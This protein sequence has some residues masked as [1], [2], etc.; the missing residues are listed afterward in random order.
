MKAKRY[1]WS[2][3]LLTV[4]AI[5]VVAF[6]AVR[7]RHADGELTVQFR[8]TQFAINLD[9]R[10]NADTE[11]R[12]IGTLLHLGLVR[13]DRDGTVLPAIASQWSQD[14]R[15]TRFAISKGLTFN[16]GSPLDLADIAASLCRSMQP[17]AIF[18][19]M[20][21]SIEHVTSA[22][23]KSVDCTGIRIDAQTREIV[24]REALSR[25]KDWLLEALASPAGWVT[26]GD[27]TSAPYR[28]VAGLGPYRLGAVVADR[29]VELVGRSGG[30][31]RPGIGR[32]VFNLITD[33]AQAVASLRRGDL[34]LLEVLNP[35]IQALLKARASDDIAIVK[36]LLSRTRILIV[37]QKALQQL[38]LQAEAAVALQAS[39]SQQ[40]DREALANTTD[41]LAEAAVSPFPFSGIHQ[42]PVNSDSGAGLSRSL[43][44]VSMNDP[45]SDR[46]AAFVA[47]SVKNPKLEYVALEK[48]VFFSRLAKG[49]FDI[50]SIA[51]ESVIEA[52]EFW[53]A[54]FTPGSPLVAFGQPIPALLKS[55]LSTK[56]ERLRALSIAQAESNWIGLLR[57]KGAFAVNKRLTGIRFTPAGQLSLEA[58]SIQ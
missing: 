23:Q 25:H 50:A 26:K 3:L 40:L 33:D 32:I 5:A 1:L 11:S 17:D 10:T 27:P 54:F 22:D 14:G 7:T 47:R 18:S 48:S 53:L 8:L 43:Q 16:D 30:P 24:L 55:P 6:Q 20:L 34:D 21:A 58:I 44:I 35:T 49:D 19:W 13:V 39:I 45:Y 31:L 29:S 15:E 9:P 51:I 4:G 12:G 2:S 41:G 57:D 28:N 52:P 56:D 42:S 37:N 36:G 46:I 38:G